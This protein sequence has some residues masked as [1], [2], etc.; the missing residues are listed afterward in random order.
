MF[1]KIFV[2]SL[3]LVLNNCSTPSITLL[4][5]AFTDPTTKSLTR[6]SLSIASKKVVKKVKNFKINQQH[7]NY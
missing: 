3:L 4:G 6:T 1:K 7:K 5:P 2:L